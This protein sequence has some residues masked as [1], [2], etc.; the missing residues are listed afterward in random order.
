MQYDDASQLRF[1]ENSKGGH[2]ESYFLRANHPTKKQALWLRYT[3]FSPAIKNEVAIAELW[4]A[5]FDNDSVIASQQDIA[6]TECDFSECKTQL[7][8]SNSH[9]EFAHKGIGHAVGEVC[10][11]ANK[12]SWHLQYKGDAQVLPLLPQKYYKRALPKAKALVSLPNALFKGTITVNGQPIEIDNWR[13]SENHNWGSQHTDEYAWGQVCGFDNMPDSFL[14]CSTARVKLGPIWSP[15]LNL[16]VLRVGQEEYRFNGVWQ[17]LK[18]S[19][20]YQ[21]FNWKMHCK[22]K[23]FTLKVV[24]HTDKKNVAG[25]NYRNPPGGSHT[26]LNSKVAGVDVMLLKGQQVIHRLHSQYGGAFEILTDDESHGVVIQNII[27]KH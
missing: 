19:G 16:A 26:C 24:M 18:N 7:K 3:L 10:D 8:I 20:Q 25:L 5:F 12:M 4:G 21:Y 2:Y 27:N 23:D 13:G 9:L 15:W 6:L 14:E 17:A 22:N 11:A 1:N